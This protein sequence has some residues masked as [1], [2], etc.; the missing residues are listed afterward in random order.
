M[1]VSNGLATCAGEAE[2]L[3]EERAAIGEFVDHVE[4][5]LSR[6]MMR[7]GTVPGRREFV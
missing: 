5:M 1:P 3:V 2:G 7:G 4:M 6:H